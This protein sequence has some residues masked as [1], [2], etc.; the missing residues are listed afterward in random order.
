MYGSWRHHGSHT[1]VFRCSFFEDN[2]VL[3]E[4]D[5]QGAS[6]NN[7]YYLRRLH[8]THPSNKHFRR[9]ITIISGEY[10]H[11]YLATDV[12]FRSVVQKT[13]VSKCF[14]TTELLILSHHPFSYSLGTTEMRPAIDCTSIIHHLLNDGQYVGEGLLGKCNSYKWTGLL[15]CN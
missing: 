4:K 10:L 1:D 9:I 7:V 14:L 15:R 12:L 2:D 8:C 6:G 11:A 13:E 5:A 3:V